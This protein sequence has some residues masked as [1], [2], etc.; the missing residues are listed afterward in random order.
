MAGAAPIQATVPANAARDSFAR[1][2][3]A[4]T[5]L[6]IAVIHA[7]MNAEGA[8]ARNGTGHFNYLN[9]QPSSNAG[10]PEGRSPGG[11]ATF[12]NV[13][14]AVTAT[15]NVLRQPNMR[16][17]LNARN[18]NDRAQIQAIAASPWDANHYRGK[19]GTIGSTLLAAYR[20][21][22]GSG[23]ITPG[24]A[25]VIG[26]GLP[27]LPDVGG[28]I[29]QATSWAEGAALRALAYVVLTVVAIALFVLGL[30]RTLGPS[31]LTRRMPYD[32]RTARIPL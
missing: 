24:A 11:F 9:L 31:P 1:G 27:G 26:T 30:E 6:S 13:D 8:Y 22:V 20:S 7:W 28:Y 3:A 16:P 15:V 14:D 32:P 17:I 12:R 23:P 19:G 2:V 4:K 29:S 18:A 21:V 10:V 25:S 5:G